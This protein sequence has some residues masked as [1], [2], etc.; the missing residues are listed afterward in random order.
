[1][2]VGADTRYQRPTSSRAAGDP[3]ARRADRDAVEPATVERD[4][5]AHIA[6]VVPGTGRLVVDEIY[7]G[8]PTTSRP[9]RPSS[10]LSLSGGLF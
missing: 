7:L 1:M 2:P 3:H 6:D 10:A 5:L 4:E 9:A 8:R